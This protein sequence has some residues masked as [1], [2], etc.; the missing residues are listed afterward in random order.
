M[1]CFGEWAFSTQLGGLQ[2]PQSR[3]ARL[4]IALLK[5]NA[6]GTQ[7]MRIASILGVSTLLRLPLRAA[8]LW[9]YVTSLVRD[10]IEDIVTTREIL[11]DSASHSKSPDDFLSTLLSKDFSHKDVGDEANQFLVA[12]TDMPCEL[13]PTLELARN[14]MLIRGD[15]DL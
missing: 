2:L 10:H 7:F 5:G 14:F 13:F 8:K 12:A 4:F 11:F 3:F 1:E 6:R 9:K 15:A